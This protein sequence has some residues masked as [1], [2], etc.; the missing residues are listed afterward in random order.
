MKPILYCI[1]TF[2]QSTTSLL[3]LCISSYGLAYTIGKPWMWDHIIVV[4]CISA[5]ILCNAFRQSFDKLFLENYII[6]NHHIIEEKHQQHLTYGTT[7]PSTI[8][9]NPPQPRY[10]SQQ[11]IHRARSLHYI[12]HLQRFDGKTPDTRQTSSG[13]NFSDNHDTQFNDIEVI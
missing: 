2:V 11:P 4:S 9:N 1:L 5:T 7:N 6:H 13:I 12:P 8:Q 3:S 10:E